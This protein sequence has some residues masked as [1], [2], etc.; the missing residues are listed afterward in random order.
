MTTTRLLPFAATKEL[1]ALFPPWM[2]CALA[3]VAIGL[4]GD[5]R[6]YALGLVASA[7]AAVALGALSIGH[8]YTHR[9]LA[10]YL[11]QPARRGQLLLIKLGVLTPMVIALS[12]LAWIA[13]LRPLQVHSATGARGWGDGWPHMVVILLPMLCGLFVAPLLT[14]L[15]RSPLAGMVFAVMVPVLVG[16]TA[17]ILAILRFGWATTAVEDS[18]DF[19]SAVFWWGMV[20]VCSV[21]AVFNW[22]MFHRLEA[23]DGPD[24]DLQL[25]TAWSRSATPVASGPAHRHPVWLLVKKELRIQ[26]MA[27]AVA[28]LYLIAW[29]TLSLLRS[30]VPEMNGPR[31]GPPVGAMALLYSALLAL[32]IGSLASAEERQYG[33]VEWQIL[34]PMASWQQWVVKATSAIILAV[35]LGIVWPT[36]LAYLHPSSDDI[37]SNGW[38]AGTV[39][40]LTAFGLYVSSLSPSGLK[41]L[42]LSIPGICVA[43]ALVGFLPTEIGRALF[44]LR[45]GRTIAASGTAA[46]LTLWLA[47]AVAAGFFALVLY[48]AMLN[49]RSSERGFARAWPQAIWMCGYLIAGFSVVSI[50]LAFQ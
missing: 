49:H 32:L 16:L 24:Q 20:G 10:L 9:T 33:T 45:W 7:F 35:L 26:Q 5:P 11:T 8:E 39:M 22:R 6:L 18:R 19:T 48:F 1:R 47:F 34:L 17:Q 44:T 4:I 50:V 37:R 38:S 42:L 25:P 31:Q 21:A 13:I 40:S 23:I 29:A 27:F 28:G 2:A 14:M 46:H 12:A 15:C 36:L 30:I 3:I 41:A 43:V